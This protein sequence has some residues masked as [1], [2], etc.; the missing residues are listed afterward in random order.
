[1]LMDTGSVSGIYGVNRIP[2]I[3]VIGPKGIVHY[4]RSGVLNE[5]RLRE[6]IDQAGQ[7]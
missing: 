5:S 2:T 1:V 6:L 3:V 7:I 4:A